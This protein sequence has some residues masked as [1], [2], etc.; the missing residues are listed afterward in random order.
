MIQLLVLY[1]LSIKATHGYEIQ[2][3]IQLNYMDEWN[4]IKSGSIYY[5]MS[6]LEKK[7]YI[8]LVEKL[9]QSEK[10]RKIYQI[11]SQGR[12]ALKKMASEELSKPLTGVKS[13]KFLVY[14][15]VASLTE[16]ELTVGIEKHLTELNQ[17]LERIE[18]WFH[19]KKNKANPI[20]LSTFNVMLETVKNQMIWHK[21]LLE[22]LTIIRRETDQ[23][24][25][26]I[27]TTSFAD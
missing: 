20:E 3:F 24:S 2:R 6:Q 10:S 21:T 22:H 15:I 16:K 25:S 9:G 11:T 12:E 27:K 23:V 17:Q 4:N 18:Y 19:E 7:A 8:S 5:A 1:F 14:P 13:E 26:M